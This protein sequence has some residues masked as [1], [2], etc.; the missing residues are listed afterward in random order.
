MACSTAALLPF[1][2]QWPPGVAHA[3][4]DAL[5]AQPPTRLLIC[6]GPPPTGT[7]LADVA[8][9]LGAL[10][11]L[12][13]TE[14]PA[15]DVLIVPHKPGAAPLRLHRALSL[16]LLPAPLTLADAPRLRALLAASAA[17]TVLPLA[18]PDALRPAD[19]LCALDA[20][21]ES[22]ATHDAVAVG[23]TF[24]HLHAGHRLLLALAALAARSVVVVGVSG[25]ALLQRKA[26]AAL[27]EPHHVRS[28]AAL[29]V[30]HAVDPRV[31][32]EVHELSEPMGP[33]AT[34]AR[35]SALVASAETAAA[36]PAINEARAARALPPLHFVVAPL[37]AP[38]HGA[39]KLSS[40]AIR[41]ALAAAAAAT[42]APHAASGG[43]AGASRYDARGVSA[44][45][46]EVH[47]AVATLDQ[48][49]VPGAFAKLVPDLLADSPL[50]AVAMHADGAGSKAALAYVYWR[51]TGDLSVWAGVA[52]DALIMNIDDL[53]CVGATTGF[54]VSSS[55][56]RNRR[57]VPGAV[58]QALIHGTEAAAA[59]LRAHG[60]E[61][62]LTGG[63][64][65]DVG[66]VVRTVLVDST[67]VAR[68]PRAAA[69]SNHAIA[70]G[71][72]VVGLA[73]EGQAAYEAAFNS[74]VGANGLTAA[75][76]DLFHAL[77][78]ERYP[79]SFDGAL[80]PAL[81]YVGPYLVTDR[82]PGLP[83]DVGRLALSPT[84][85]YAPV[86]RRL[87]AALPPGALHGAVHCTGGGQ[88]KV[89]H[90]CPPGVHI[91]KDALFP[92]PALMR[93]L[94]AQSGTAWREMYQ[95]FNMGH[96]ME[97]YVAPAHAP[98]VIDAAR[99]VGVA[100]QIVGRVA[101]AEPTAKRLTIRS[102]H[103]DFAYGTPLPH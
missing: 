28:A 64:T 75:R 34:D 81:A 94:Q 47:A 27:L 76:H 79:E 84:R 30:L 24:D 52:Q 92:L 44:Q 65:A 12:L 5:G 55:I 18:L 2:A 90:T 71:D 67:V 46:E 80:S 17:P 42:S 14:L 31:R 82:L 54:L 48:G 38:P 16:L 29:R 25:A 53:L 102:E 87:A 77:Y 41:A 58:V 49:V 10:Y 39:D 91:V 86:F 69:I 89:L 96:R 1:A 70:P 4:R 95:V 85:S 35:L 21:A 73:S 51:E 62:H 36:L 40:T 33:A 98:A 26:H 78:A 72:V 3:L 20:A 103:G 97:L 88:T 23:G 99:A 74:G 61:V 68:L 60:V 32:C 22:A 19:A 100:A 9:S 11:S 63:E 7:S 50:H 8:A 13:H 6:V 101:A 15:L 66:D 83:L 37:V 59:A 56:A 43:A 57:L 45:K 93:L